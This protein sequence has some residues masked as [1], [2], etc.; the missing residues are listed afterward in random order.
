MTVKANN[1]R[2]ANH[3]VLVHGGFVD[4]SGWVGVYRELKNK[5]YNSHGRAEP[6]H[7]PGRRCRRDKKGNSR[8]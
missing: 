4:S 1:G 5:G 7:F 8:A 6:H 2:L 3:A